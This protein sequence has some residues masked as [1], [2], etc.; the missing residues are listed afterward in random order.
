MSVGNLV[1]IKAE[2]NKFTSRPMYIITKLEKDK[3]VLQK[4]GDKQFSSRQYV[5]PL[6]QV[7]PISSRTV[8]FEWDAITD[9]LEEESDS[10]IELN[11]QSEPPATNDSQED[12]HTGVQLSEDSDD[13]DNEGTEPQVRPIRERRRPPWQNDYVCS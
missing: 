2:S 3:V 11:E 5:V 7:F 9:E 10:D 4:V 1:Y 12:Q 6:A 8:N 13:S